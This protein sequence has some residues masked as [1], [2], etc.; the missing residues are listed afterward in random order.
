VRRL[1][2]ARL[3]HENNSF[4]PTTIQLEHF[5]QRE[6]SKQRNHF[7]AASAPVLSAT[8]E[9]DAP[10]PAALDLTRLPFRYAPAYLYRGASPR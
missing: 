4:S 6:S 1:A 9:V 10:G 8:V 3:W 5:R 2:V 7:R